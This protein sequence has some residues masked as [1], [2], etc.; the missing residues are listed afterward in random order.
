[1]T[2]IT[3]SKLEITNIQV[4]ALVTKCITTVWLSK[5]ESEGQKK[6]CLNKRFS[7]NGYTR[8]RGACIATV[9]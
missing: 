1:M 9:I 2:E 6:P 7:E 8:H 5:Q 4:V 3:I